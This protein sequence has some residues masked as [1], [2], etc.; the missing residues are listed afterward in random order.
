MTS[1]LDVWVA[2]AQFY[3]KPETIAGAMAKACEADCLTVTDVLNAWRVWM[4]DGKPTMPSYGDILRI[5]RPQ[6][7]SSPRQ[8]A[9]KAAAMVPVLIAKHGSWWSHGV[10]NGDK[11]QFEGRDGKLYDTFDDAVKSYLGPVAP[12]VTQRWQYL[13]EHWDEN[14][15][16]NHAQMRDLFE[17]A[18]QESSSQ[19]ELGSLLSYQNHQIEQA[20]KQ[21]LAH[22]QGG[23][24][25]E[26]R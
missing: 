24:A 14:I 8:L 17:G 3:G 7:T 12:L 13:C 11:Q 9:A 22:S 15:S 6:D 2:I 23:E 18:I 10:W 1:M 25:H 26:N 21:L 19:K 5:A 20:H 4:R 16:A